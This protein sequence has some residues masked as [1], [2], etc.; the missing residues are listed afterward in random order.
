MPELWDVGRASGISALHAEIL[1]QAG[2]IG[3]NQTFAVIM[4]G[5]LCAAPIALLFRRARLRS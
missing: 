5:A 4:V 3:Y 2:M 1:R